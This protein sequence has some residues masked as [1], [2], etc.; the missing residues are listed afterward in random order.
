M[1]YFVFNLQM[2]LVAGSGPGSAAQNSDQSGKHSAASTLATQICIFMHLTFTMW[3]DDD[4]IEAGVSIWHSIL[5]LSVIDVRTEAIQ[6]GNI[7]RKK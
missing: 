7:C 3:H 5:L 4:S 2:Q 6:A 1:V